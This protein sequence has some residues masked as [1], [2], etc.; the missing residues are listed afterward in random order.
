MRMI[1]DFFAALGA[2]AGFRVGWKRV[3]HIRYGHPYHKSERLDKLRSEQHPHTDSEY[4]YTVNIM[5]CLDCGL[6]YLDDG[7]E[8]RI[9]ELP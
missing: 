1:F 4:I 7:L 6:C 8:T 2:S 5:K 9:K 3:R